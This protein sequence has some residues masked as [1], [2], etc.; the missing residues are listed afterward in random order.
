[1]R[2]AGDPPLRLGS[3]EQDVRDAVKSLVFVTKVE[4]LAHLM[5]WTFVTFPVYMLL[6]IYLFNKYMANNI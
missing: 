1:M 6:A 3:G 2:K 4:M 5:C